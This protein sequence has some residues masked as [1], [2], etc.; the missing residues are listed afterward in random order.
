MLPRDFLF[1]PYYTGFDR[2]MDTIMPPSVHYTPKMFIV[3]MGIS[4]L[5]SKDGSGP[6]QTRKITTNY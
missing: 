5:F 4:I 3:C 2:V 6:W 1:G